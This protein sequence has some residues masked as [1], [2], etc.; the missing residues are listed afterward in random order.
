MID[1]GAFARIADVGSISGGGRRTRATGGGSGAMRID[2]V[3]G[4]VRKSTGISIVLGAGAS[5]TA[6]IPLAPGLVET[7][8][9][10][11][12]HC[13]VGLSEAERRDY[14]HVMGALDPS[15]RKAVIQPLLDASRIN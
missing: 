6:G 8:N 3:A 15:Q 4:Y 7:I 12:S 10:D 2:E 1:L 13:L 5:L 11:H 14:G 9:R